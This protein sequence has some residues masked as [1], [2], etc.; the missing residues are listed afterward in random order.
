VEFV[1]KVL[2][3]LGFIVIGADLSHTRFA[4]VRWGLLVDHLVET[5]L[6]AWAA[7]AA[8]GAREDAGRA[9]EYAKTTYKIIVGEDMS[10]NATYG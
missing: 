8:M 10:F 9:E 2:T 1:G 3:P 6:H 4:V 5:F 7:F